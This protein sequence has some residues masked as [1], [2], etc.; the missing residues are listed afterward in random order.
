MCGFRSSDRVAFSVQELA[1]GRLRRSA[2]RMQSP[3]R[4]KQTSIGSVSGNSTL[5]AIWPQPA[6]A[7]WEVR[8]SA[9]VTF[10]ARAARRD[11][12]D[13]LRFRSPRRPADALEARMI[14]TARL[15]LRPWRDSDREPFARMSA[16]PEVM[17]FLPGCLSRHDSDRLADSISR[18]LPAARVRRLRGRVARGGDLHRVHR[19][20]GSRVRRAPTRAPG[21]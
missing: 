13:G 15:T 17:E 14:D 7:S 11:R 1:G 3:F 10:H 16:D 2:H 4:D 19:A 18:S 20:F 21:A 6:A 8:L 5:L 9:G 12:E